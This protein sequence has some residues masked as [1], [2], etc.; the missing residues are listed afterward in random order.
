M[1]DQPDQGT[2][3][4]IGNFDLGNELVENRVRIMVLNQIVN[5]LI[6]ATAANITQDEVDQMR[7]DAVARLNEQYPELGIQ[8]G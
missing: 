1:E 7:Q 8:E 3:L 6:N 4:A 5:R 2:G